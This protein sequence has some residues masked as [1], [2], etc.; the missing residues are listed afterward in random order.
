VDTCCIDKS[1]N[2]ELSEAIN[3]MFNWYKRARVCYTYL[4]DVR[5]GGL[6]STDINL[7]RDRSVIRSA[8]KF[9]VKVT[10][11]DEPTDGEPTNNSP[12]LLEH[13]VH[14]VH[15]T[16]IKSI[17]DSRWFERGW[18]LQ[19]LIAPRFLRFYDSSW[20][21]LGD[22]DQELSDVVCGCTGLTPNIMGNPGDLRYI[23][24]ARRMSWM[25]RRQ[26]TRKEDIAYCLLGIFGVNMPLLY[27]EEEK[28]FIRLQEEIARRN[29]DHSL[30]VFSDGSDPNQG[31]RRARQILATS[32]SDFAMCYNLE[33]CD[34]F[35][36]QLAAEPCQL[37]SKGLHIS[38]PL[39]QTVTDDLQPD[40]YGG[41]IELAV[42]SYQIDGSVIGLVLHR[43]P[44]NRKV[45]IRYIGSTHRTL[46]H[47]KVKTL[48]PG[49]ALV[50]IPRELAMTA[51]R[52][53]IVI[54]GD[55]H[56]RQHPWP[57]VLNAWLR[58][59]L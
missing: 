57:L 44:Y 38:L 4:A 35:E 17:H 19:E 28:A 5:T 33:L 9:Q 41:R 55:E 34:I 50:S 24:I 26:T 47:G 14:T 15:A 27:G 31:A 21:Y 2:A 52:A 45:N 42:L 23:P 16:V 48:W 3:S 49:T 13:S 11:N 40:D 54:R 30:F 18:T 12:A 32:P 46:M 53:T 25:A 59:A 7:I 43:V 51:T 6:V 10:D 1:N 8:P 39:L 58:S 20:H 36:D 37:T 22:R 56:L 29:E